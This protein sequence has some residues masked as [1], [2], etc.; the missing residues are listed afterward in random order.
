MYS[1]FSATTLL[2][3]EINKRGQNPFLKVS[4]KDGRGSILRLLKSSEAQND[5][6]RL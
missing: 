2:K 5:Q 1:T 6:G 3:G 4:N